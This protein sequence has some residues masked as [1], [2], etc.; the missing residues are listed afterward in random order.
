MMSSKEISASLQATRAFLSDG[1]LPS[2]PLRDADI[3][4]IDDTLE[5]LEQ[6]FTLAVIGEFSSG[7]SYLLNALLGKVYRQEGKITGL[8][9]VDINPSTAT[10]T[11]LE[12]GAE[13]SAI[14][15]YPSGRT[16]RIPPAQLSRFVAV[17]AGTPGALHDA[18][19]DDDS[20]PT[21]VVVH[22]DS[23]FLQRGFTIADTPGLASLNPAH[24]R[25]TL[26][27]LPRTDAV[28][29]L[30]DTQQP[31]TDGDAA[32][33]GL[34]SEHVRAIFIVQTKIDLWHTPESNGKE[35]WEN[36]R[37][38]IIAHAAQYAPTAEVFAV[39]SR[40]FAIGQLDDDAALRERSGFPKLLTALN[41]SLEDLVRSARI[42]RAIDTAEYV[43]SRASA[44]FERDHTLMESDA[45]T[46]QEQYD[47][48]LRNLAGKE[49]ALAA[50]R[51]A[52]NAE[53]IARS[54]HIVARTTTLNDEL[55]RALSS[56]FDIK[57]IDHIRDRGKLHALTDA[58]AAH[59]FGEFANE[60]AHD[61]AS[62][63]QRIEHK[64]PMLRVAERT[65]LLLGGE[66]GAGSWSRDLTSGIR[67]TIILDAIGGPTVS[68]VHAVA[69]TFAAHVYGTY[70]KRE[71]RSDL[72]E[73]FFPQLTADVL[74]FVQ[75]IATR[76]GT[77]YTDIANT[78]DR[79]RNTARAQSLDP[80]EHALSL[81]N[82]E[83][84]RILEKKRI[85]DA[86]IKAEELRAA[87]AARAMHAQTPGRH[88]P[89]NISKP[90]LD[91]VPFDTDIYQSGLNPQ[92]LRVVV[93]GALHRGKSSLINAIAG[94][95]LLRDEGGAEAM[96]PIHVR[97]GPEDHA[98]ALLHEGK[99]HEIPLNT[100]MEQAAHTAVLIE[101]PWKMPRELVLVHAPA[102]DSGS[103]HAEEITLTAVNAANQVAALFS[104]QLAE[105][106]LTLYKRIAALGKPMYFVHTIA[107][108]EN[109]SER[110]TVVELATRYLREREIPFVRIF[111]ISALDYYKATLAGHAPSAWNELG[112][113]R[114][115][116]AAQ[117]EEHMQRLA[118]LR[119]EPP[120][121]PATAAAAKPLSLPARIRTALSRL[122]SKQ[123]A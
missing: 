78:I 44:R 102:F 71:L 32:F 55:I 111:T 62:E 17:T 19:A 21:H 10:I 83:A 36:A 110:R 98:Y 119:K 31:F 2:W 121:H 63:L 59:V 14:A 107:D 89:S 23:P 38:R 123:G 27:Y 80:I 29:Y 65:A 75:N 91:N 61:T 68:F 105:G 96:Y 56:A 76:I 90:L 118:L 13:E 117:A 95:H 87:F 64:H 3:A 94:T 97:Y 100:A 51:D 122:R 28:L 12:F 92:R 40:D 106:E 57:D 84:A 16:E 46:L 81:A 99:W 103:P 22:T 9:T 73:R 34:I 47:A 88:A 25:A 74:T 20:A 15:R 33:L 101:L 37:D 48:A 18:L 54:A 116:L 66:P 52:I 53:G 41:E 60:T 67:S 43:L 26:G 58:V 115:T 69:D 49:D 114:D 93:L 39:S 112:A 50:Q 7:K 109:P 82:D 8:L 42:M 120:P 1:D 35:S 6:R 45:A 70:M 77:I 113:L 85:A 5:R 79:E 4:L 86:H 30:I 108:N 72:R 11:E 24:R 104:R